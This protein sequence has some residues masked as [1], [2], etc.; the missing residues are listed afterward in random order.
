M[1]IYEITTI[2]IVLFA[3]IDYITTSIA[4]YI[5]YKKNP[6][7]DRY[8]DFAKICSAFQSVW[9]CYRPL[10]PVLV[11]SIIVLNSLLFIFINLFSI[12]VA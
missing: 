1:T 12:N 11:L 7:L 8:T 10:L 5:Y 6:L 2:V 3:L 4:L 9:W